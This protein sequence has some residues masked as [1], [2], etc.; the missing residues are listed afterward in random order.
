MTLATQRAIR[1]IVRRRSSDQRCIHAGRRAVERPHTSQRTVSI[2]SMTMV[3]TAWRPRRA[4]GMRA[5]MNSAMRSARASMRGGRR[6]EGNGGR[7]PMWDP[8]QQTSR[9]GEVERGAGLDRSPEYA[10]AAVVAGRVKCRAF[11]DRTRS[12]DRSRLRM[13]EPVSDPMTPGAISTGRAAKA[14]HAPVTKALC[15][16]AERT[17]SHP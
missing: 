12:A 7:Q 4:S 15:T 3:A 14:R 5:A 1:R 8:S 6:R 10:R 13:D 9:C 17:A 16:D 2:A 11:V